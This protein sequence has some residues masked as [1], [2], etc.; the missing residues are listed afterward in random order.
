MAKFLLALSLLLGSLVASGQVPAATIPAFSFS[1]VDN[2]SFTRENLVK[3]K[4]VFFVFF[5]TE[6]DHCRHA[7][8][9]LDKQHNKLGNT[10]VYLLTLEDTERAKSF[11]SKFGYNLLAKKNVTLLRDTRSEFIAKFKPRKYPSLFLFSSTQR[12]LLYDDD[13]VSLPKFLQQIAAAER[14]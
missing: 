3:G 2:S 13:P 5:D 7:I 12:L 4:Q 1:R 9:Y 8:Q 10:A 6:C 14:R 11:L